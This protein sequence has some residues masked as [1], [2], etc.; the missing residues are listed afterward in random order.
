MI[1]LRSERLPREML[2]QVNKVL[3]A[4]QNAAEA[5]DS[6]CSLIGVK[7][8]SYDGPAPEAGELLAWAIGTPEPVLFCPAPSENVR[9]RHRRKYAEGELGPER[10]FY[11]RGPENK[12]KLRAQ[13]LITFLNLLK[14]VDDETWLFHLRNGEYSRWFREQI[15]DD[16]MA[17]EAEAIERNGFDPGESRQ[18]MHRLVTGRYTL[19]A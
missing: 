16:D 1:T 10:S 18:K 14:G 4:G 19:P 17:A 8:P 9:I 15:K 11:F 3:V 12:L 7:P 13:N 2:V 6:F 5:I